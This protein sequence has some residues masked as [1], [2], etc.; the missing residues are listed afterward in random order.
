[1]RIENNPFAAATSVHEGTHTQPPGTEYISED[2]TDGVSA[3][4]SLDSQAVSGLA[5]GED[6]RQDRVTAL[7]QAIDTGTYQVNATGIAAAM[8]DNMA[9]MRFAV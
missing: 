4:L 5:K 7:K 1:M 6:I 3:R 9:T 2:Q 8:M